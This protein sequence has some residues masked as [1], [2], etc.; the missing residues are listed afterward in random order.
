MGLFV[1]S[2]AEDTFTIVNTAGI[3]LRPAQMIA[4]LSASFADCEVFASKDGVRAN[5][6][7]IMSI[8]ELIGAC[9]SQVAFEI[10]GE[11]ADECLGQLRAL[12]ADG[13]GEEIDPQYQRPS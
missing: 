11:R 8:I 5:A 7:S 4:R 1:L 10:R 12:F 2:V 13:F 9:G 3:H 6:K